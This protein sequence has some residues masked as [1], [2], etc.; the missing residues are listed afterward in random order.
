MAQNKKKKNRSNA[1]VMKQR[2]M[3]E[4]M[5]K[6]ALGVDMQNAYNK[7]LNNGYG[8]AVLIMFWLM[9]TEHGFGKKRL[10]V[11]M[12]K[13]NDFCLEMLAPGP[14]GP[15]KPKSGEFEGIS[16]KDIAD[17]LAEECGI[18]IDTD[19]WVMEVNNIEI[20]REGEQHGIDSV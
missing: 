10:A 3:H 15:Q 7:G 8:I 18:F 13:I 5:F 2:A 9:H 12:R 19:T 11:L 20:V 17:Q 6:N 14:D 16:L 1:A 4:M